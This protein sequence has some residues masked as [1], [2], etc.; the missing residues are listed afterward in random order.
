MFLCQVYASRL[1][2]RVL[3][4]EFPLSRRLFEEVPGRVQELL[5]GPDGP[6][7]VLN[8]RPLGSSRFFSMPLGKQQQQ[9]LSFASVEER[10]ANHSD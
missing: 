2:P 1:S 5:G 6:A 4:I 7:R 3:Y 9:F 10:K 8:V